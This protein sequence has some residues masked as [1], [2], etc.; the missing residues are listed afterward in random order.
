MSILVID[1]KRLS[2]DLIVRS[3][4]A[5]GETAYAC[6]DGASAIEFMEQHR[7]TLVLTDWH[8]SPI[9]GE[10]VLSA[11]RSFDPPIEVVV[12]TGI[13]DIQ[14]AVT[15]LRLGARDF[16]IKPVSMDQIAR[17]IEEVRARGSGTVETVAPARLM[18]GSTLAQARS[19]AGR[20]LWKDIENASRAS[21]PV[22]IH[23]EVG[24]GRSSVAA[25]IHEMSERSG[26]L[27]ILPVRSSATW[28]WPASGAV[29]INDFEQL[30]AFQ[31]QEIL[32]RLE[33]KPDGIRVF[34]TATPPP[35][36]SPPSHPAWD[37]LYY[38]LAVLVIHIPPL[39]ERRE[40]IAPLFLHALERLALRYERPTPTIS[41][42]YLAELQT[43]S[44]PGNFRELV[45]E[46][47]R[48]VI[49]GVEGRASASPQPHVA[50]PDDTL[51]PCPPARL[52]GTF[53]LSTYL[54][55]VERR[56]IEHALKLGQNDRKV[57]GELLGVERN[58]LRYKLK[59]YDLLD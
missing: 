35:Y 58:A 17:R 4:K 21:S 8:M 40:D 27:G 38:K 36:L 26:P 53:A 7:P 55:D 47:E 19:A 43:R 49:F 37:T 28:R 50:T 54:D 31:I 48:A 46:A 9:G 51:V 11:A 6:Y 30:N 57:A 13:S 29:L 56:V 32:K 18:G 41:E 59:K 25:S 24:T 5:R 10:E 20:Q 14:T 3:L 45:N 15:A 33:D 16:L 34:C 12:F 42:A 2:A 39:R 44:W 52:G 22:F 23:G 1:D